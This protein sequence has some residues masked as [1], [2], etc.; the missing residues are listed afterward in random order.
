VRRHGELH[1]ALDAGLLTEDDVHAELGLVAAGRATGRTDDD[2]ITVA[3]LT[4]LGIQDTAV[5]A[6]VMRRA[7]EQGLGRMLA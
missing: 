2:Q 7:E 1:H 4:G 6:L 3:D 5:A